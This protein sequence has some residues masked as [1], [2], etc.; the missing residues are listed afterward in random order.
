MVVA[1]KR[2]AVWCI[3]GV[4]GE[5]LPVI[6]DCSARRLIVNADDFGLSRSINEGILHAFR[7]GI[8]RSVSLV[9]AG[10]AFEHAVAAVQTESGL[11][12]GVHLTAVEERP[13]RSIAD[14]RCLVRGQRR[15]PRAPLGTLTSLLG[16]R[17]AWLE[18]EGEFRAQINAVLLRG[19]SISHLDCHRHLQVI[20]NVFRLI[21]RL[22]QDYR[23]PWVRIPLN[24]T[25]VRDDLRLFR[26]PQMLAAHLL[27]RSA[28]RFLQTGAV[29]LRASDR[30][31]GM[32]VSGR[33]DEQWL[34]HQL[35]QLRSGITELMCHPGFESPGM[36]RRYA[37]WGGYRWER[38]VEALTSPRVRQALLDSGIRLTSFRELADEPRA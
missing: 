19:I 38:E 37:N 16:S 36:R 35:R 32:T 30:L 6:S 1:P 11:D 2:L 23:I 15:F 27:C 8:V 12:V 24:P 33:L 18:L 17:S 20:P 21:C 7:H 3:A 28:A 22:A 13:V 5:T 4:S 9:V 25:A 31:L 34:M 29:D 14:V 26:S 10:R